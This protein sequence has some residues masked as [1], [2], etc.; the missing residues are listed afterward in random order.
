V[1]KAVRQGPPEPES[2]AI[3]DLSKCTNVDPAS[4]LLF[5]YTSRIL[6]RI[7]W[8]TFIEQRSALSPA[9]AAL[10]KHVQHLQAEKSKRQSQPWDPGEYPLRGVTSQNEMVGELQEWAQ[11]VQQATSVS[12]EELARWTTHVSELTTNS[13]QHAP[14]GFAG[15]LGDILI[16]GEAKGGAI[17]LATLDTGSGIPA[18]LRPHV[19]GN[20]H[21]GQ[22]ITRACQERV[23]SR[24]SRANQG[25]GLFALSEAVKAARGTLQIL[26]GN[27]RSHV[28][29][30]RSYAKCLKPPS[31][32][33]QSLSGTLTVVGLTVPGLRARKR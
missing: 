1:V 18:V 10:L 22:I 33:A 9:F 11:C 6:A 30:G 28:R 14:T 26:S 24:C 20:L 13:F 2:R 7:G 17:Q 31:P 29:N 27:G 32:I 3:F 19:A 23:T 8:D 5:V 25:L 12:E 15:T 4:I 16:A 21:D